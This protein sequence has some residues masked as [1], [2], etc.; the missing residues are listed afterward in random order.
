MLFAIAVVAFES[1]SLE[2]AESSTASTAHG[3]SEVGFSH[4]V[5]VPVESNPVTCSAR[6][7]S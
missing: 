3:C 7:Y 5:F 1:V 6:I 4:F 2:F